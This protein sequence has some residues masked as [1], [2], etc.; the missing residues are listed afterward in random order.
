M[1]DDNHGAVPV[2]G[3]SRRSMLK[4]GALVGAT[5]VWAV[6]AIQAVSMTPAHA[7]T[8]SAP[9]GGGGI[10][11]G[12]D[13]PPVTTVPT[14]DPPTTK[15]PST[16]TPTTKTQTSGGGLGVDGAVTTR[17]PTHRAD[18][19]GVAGVADTKPLAATGPAVPVGATALLG[20][21]AVALG[22]GVVA[23]ARPRREGAPEPKHE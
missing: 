8:P 20:T 4:R 6:P 15:V 10:G 17:K 13:G 16:D 21:A 19:A 9:G 22:A 12:G 11:G 18:G 14:T 5:A 2:S 3:I 1:M 23:A 7:D